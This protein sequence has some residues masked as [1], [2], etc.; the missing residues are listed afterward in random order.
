MSYRRD[1]T[2]ARKWQLWVEHNR[3]ELLACG[4]PQVVFGEESHWYYFLEHDY[5]TPLGSAEPIIDVDRME[6]QQALRLCLFLEG[7]DLYPACAALNRLQFLL[8]RGI[9]EKSGG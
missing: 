9:H 4:V 6:E 1:K 3:D 2:A 5:F 8:K 7:D